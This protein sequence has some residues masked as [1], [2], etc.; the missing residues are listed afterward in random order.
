VLDAERVN[1][2]DLEELV[3]AHKVDEYAEKYALYR[4]E[5]Q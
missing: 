4:I 1:K 5:L 3:G 2:R